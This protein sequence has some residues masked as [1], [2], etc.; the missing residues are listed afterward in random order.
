M[1]EEGGGEVGGRGGGRRSCT[2]CVH[3]D[4][5]QQLS[6]PLNELRRFIKAYSLVIASALDILVR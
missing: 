1:V 5:R 2:K 3:I 6:A 4:D